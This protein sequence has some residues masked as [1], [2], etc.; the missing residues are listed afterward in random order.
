MAYE[1][2]RPLS[3]H[4]QVYRLPLTAVVSIIHRLTGL[5]IVLGA[6]LLIVVLFS[7]AAGPQSYATA[8]A[9][10]DSWIGRL[11]LIGL[12]LALYF[13]LCNG[14]RHLFW[15]IGYGFELETVDRTALATAVGALVL[16]SATWLLA[17]L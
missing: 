11:L 9:A 13:H 12:T 2:E 4:L 17:L 7:V 14:V 6:V 8:Q 1:D 3:P 10:L 15:D 5:V 16:T